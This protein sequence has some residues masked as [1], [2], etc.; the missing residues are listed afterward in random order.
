MSINIEERLLGMKA[1]EK[2]FISEKQLVKSLNHIEFIDPNKSLE[3][4]FLDYGY[5]TPAQISRLKKQLSNIQHLM[6]P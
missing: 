2:R 1:V 3:Q 5:L 4:V 6:T